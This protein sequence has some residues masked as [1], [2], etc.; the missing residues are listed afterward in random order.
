MTRW[1]ILFWGVGAGGLL[2]QGKDL[3]LT[4]VPTGDKISALIDFA[5][6]ATLSPIVA[7]WNESMSIPASQLD[8]PT[9]WVVR[10]PV[11]VGV[12]LR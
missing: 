4:A 1:G 11:V 12:G 10:L 2:F 3:C 7:P 9:P 8:G 6:L 5:A